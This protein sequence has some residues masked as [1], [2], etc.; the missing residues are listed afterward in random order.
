MVDCDERYREKGRDQ[1]AERCRLLQDYMADEMWPEMG[2]NS[3]RDG[4]A[5]DR[6]NAV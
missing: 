3:V 5:V 1:E 6:E 2:G 4:K